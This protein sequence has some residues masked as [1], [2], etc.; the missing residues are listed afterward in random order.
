MQK[1]WDHLQGVA[2]AIGLLILIFDSNRALEGARSG[3]ELC[4]RTVIPSLFPFLVL[5][6]PLTSSHG[7]HNAYLL[8]LLGKGL[9][10]PG[11]CES[12]LIPAFLGG[13]PVGAKCVSDFYLKKQISKKEAQRLLSF[14]SNAGPA[15]LFGIVSGFFPTQTMVW[16]LWFIHILSAALTSAAIPAGR[17]V[18]NLSHSQPTAQTISTIWSA[19]KA[20]CLICCWVILFRILI[21]FLNAWFLWMLPQWLQTLF[22]GILELTNGCCELILIQDIKLRFVVCSCTLA[23]G[24]ICVLFQTISVIQGLSIG[25][26]IRGKLIQTAFSF[27]LSCAVI[28]EH[29]WIFAGMIAVLIYILRKTQKS[30]SFPQVIPV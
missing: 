13:Y 27:L 17:S 18:H 10:I 4:I 30:C 25:S 23:F 22:T 1:K 19:A 21:T 5:S 24:G 8:Q 6:M 11:T 26:Y 20:M 2:A 28:G 15:F 7:N 9:G 12:I 14:C 3:V 29:R 16:I